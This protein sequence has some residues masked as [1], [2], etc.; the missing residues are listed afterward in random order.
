VIQKKIA[1]LGAA[2]VGKTSLVRRFVDSLFD[3]KYL[4]TIGVKV[5]KRPVRVGGDEVNLVIWD[6]AGAEEHFSVPTSYIRGAAGYLLVA[7]GTRP[8][9]FDTAAAIVEQI[10]RDLGPLP[11]IVVVNKKDLVDAWRADGPAIDALAPRSLGV[12]HSSAKTGE[13]VEE[14]FQQLA[15]AL[16]RA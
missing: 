3:D 11:F 2:G 8:A 1:L 5:D 14:A 12:L 6:V 9:T 7:D 4:T 10:E 15:N 16:V 13:A